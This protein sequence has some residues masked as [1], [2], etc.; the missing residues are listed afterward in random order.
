MVTAPF[1]LDCDT[2]IDDALAIAYLLADPAAELVAV[3][4]VFGNTRVEQAAANN[5]AVLELAGRGDIPVAVGASHPLAREFRG[6]AAH[7]HGDNGIG[8]VQLP[9]ARAIAVDEPAP[10][11]IGRL[12]REHGGELHLVATGPLTNLALAL[13]L[14]PALPGLVAG[15]TIM[16]GAAI[17]PGN[18]TP[19]GEANIVNDPEA[20]QAVLTAGWSD[21][22]LVPLDVTMQHRLT[23]I[24]QHRLVDSGQPLAIALGQMVRSYLDFYTSVFGVRECAL[25]DPLAAAIATGSAA[26]AIAPTVP[27]QVDVTDGPG[28]GQTICD[29]RGRFRGYPPL[30]EANCRVVLALTEPFA[31]LLMNRIL[32]RP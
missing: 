4:S 17:A 23:E 8:G 5:L 6:G 26:T 16:G 27:V 7:V 14:E 1:L 29:L 18:T 10:E 12:A 32:T 22:T 31:P 2:G 13:Q 30:P 20:A 19:V 3:T 25:H 11:M 24:D 9:V 21:L 28:R 15:L